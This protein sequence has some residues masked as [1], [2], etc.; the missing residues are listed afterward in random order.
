MNSLLLVA[1]ALLAVGVTVLIASFWSA[2]FAASPFTFLRTIARR[3]D[4]SLSIAYAIAGNI[5]VTPEELDDIAN[6]SNQYLRCV[7]AAHSSANPETLRRLSQDESRMVRL[8]LLENPR[9]PDDVAA[10]VALEM[11]VDG[12]RSH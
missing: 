12:P 5:R 10:L 2:L 8:R 9:T 4:S 7:V 11:M 3:F 1:T 6:D